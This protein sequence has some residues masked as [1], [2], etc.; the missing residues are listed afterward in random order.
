MTLS[1]AVEL[2]D[3]IAALGG[4]EHAAVKRHRAGYKLVVRLV[5]EPPRSYVNHDRAFNHYCASLDE[6]DA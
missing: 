4:C 2:R 6:E 3:F 5:G 1:E